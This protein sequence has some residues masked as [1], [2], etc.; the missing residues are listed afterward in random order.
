MKRRGGIRAFIALGLPETTQKMLEDLQGIMPGGRLSAPETLHLTLA[1]LNTLPESMVAEIH[2]NLCEIKAEPVV[3]TLSGVDLYRTG[4]SSIVCVRAAASPALTDLRGK[5]RKA[6]MDAG[7][8][9]RRERFRPHVTLVRISAGA[10]NRQKSRI[11]E[12]VARHSAFHLEP[13]TIDSFHLYRSTLGEAGAV[14][15]ILEDYPLGIQIST[16]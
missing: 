11:A 10:D 6:V 1:F 13:A 7:L 12:F 3:V 5:V 14:Y 15:D 4:R 8:H 9:L 2:G 16:D